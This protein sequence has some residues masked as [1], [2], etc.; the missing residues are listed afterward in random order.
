MK[1]LGDLDKHISVGVGEGG[2][3]VKSQ[4]VIDSREKVERGGYNVPNPV[5][6]CVMQWSRETD[7][8]Y[9]C[10]LHL[11]THHCLPEPSPSEVEP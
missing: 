4:S 11:V 9:F 6:H 10:P 8:L 5:G 1:V 3:V 7:V 2:G